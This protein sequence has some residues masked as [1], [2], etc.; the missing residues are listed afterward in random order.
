MRARFMGPIQTV[1]SPAGLFLGTYY[2][3]NDNEG[4]QAQVE[5]FRAMLK[6]MKA[7]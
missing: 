4:V 5:S 6:Y 7:K 3:E 1:W 2:G